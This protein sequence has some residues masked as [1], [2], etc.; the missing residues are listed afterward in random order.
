MVLDFD[1]GVGGRRIVTCGDKIE[2][3]EGGVSVENG[4]DLDDEPGC[5]FHMLRRTWMWLATCFFV[6]SM[7]DLWR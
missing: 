4:E 1:G 6:L 5:P 2:L 7:P 3:W